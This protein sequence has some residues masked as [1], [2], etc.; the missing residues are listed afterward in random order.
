ME[1]KKSP[2]SLEQ[3]GLCKGFLRKEILHMRKWYE[4]GKKESLTLPPVSLIQDK[5][6]TILHEKNNEEM[7]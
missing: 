1:L 7:Y 4:I 6:R 3:E 2:S 5:K